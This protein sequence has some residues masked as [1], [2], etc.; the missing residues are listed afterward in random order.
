MSDQTP[1]QDEYGARFHTVTKIKHRACPGCAPDFTILLVCKCT[2]RPREEW[3]PLRGHAALRDHVNAE[4]AH[5]PWI[6]IMAVLDSIF[7]ASGS[8]HY[9][10][11]A[12]GPRTLENR[13]Q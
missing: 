9:I 4:H 6:Y 1:G 5:E 7:P 12:S 2:C 3:T 13:I 11:V 8:P 10:Y